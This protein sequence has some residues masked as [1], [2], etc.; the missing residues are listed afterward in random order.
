[1]FYIVTV[2]PPVRPYIR[3]SLAEAFQ[4]ACAFISRGFKGVAINK[5]RGGRIEGHVLTKACENGELTL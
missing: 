2:P 4:I 5:Y 1:M 3:H